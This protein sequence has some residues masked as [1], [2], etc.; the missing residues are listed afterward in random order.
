MLSELEDYQGGIQ[1]TARLPRLPGRFDIRLFLHLSLFLFKQ[2]SLTTM[3]AD[4]SRRLVIDLSAIAEESV[5]EETL[6]GN[7]PTGQTEGVVEG[8]DVACGDTVM[9]GF[10]T[11]KR[12]YF[13]PPRNK[14]SP[15]ESLFRRELGYSRIAFIANQSTIF[16]SLLIFIQTMLYF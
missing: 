9:E 12:N 11:V 16:C 10:Q 2:I 13:I 8:M 7:H 4:D 14:L 5:T 1:H 6:V 15:G 3:A